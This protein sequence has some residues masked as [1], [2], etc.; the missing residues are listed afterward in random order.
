MPKILNPAETL[1]LAKVISD[2]N[3]KAIRE[4]VAPGAYPVDFACRLSG[5]LIVNDGILVRPT[6]TL[7]CFETLAMIFQKL[8]VNRVSALQILREVATDQLLRG[9]VVADGITPYIEDFEA[10]LGEYGELLNSLPKIPRKGSVSAKDV[11]VL[12]L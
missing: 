6:S 5:S 3:Q 8:G 7:F 10:F 9:K 12:K 11:S 4:A 1:T 2:A